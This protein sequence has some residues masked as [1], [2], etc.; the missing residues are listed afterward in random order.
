MKIHRDQTW[1]RR[2]LSLLWDSD[3]LARIVAPGDVVSLRQ[4]CAIA[5]RWPAELPGADGDAL[6][7]AGLEG[8]LDT[9]APD[10]AQTWLEHD[11]KQLILDFQ[12]EYEGSAA[13]IFWLPAGRRRL[14]M[15]RA[16]EAYSW[17]HS[18]AKKPHLPLGRYLWAGAESDVARILVSDEANPDPDGPAY[19]GLYHPRIS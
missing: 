17:Q 6:I 16:T 15:S 12:N 5:R 7:V 1:T 2:G 9:L 11:L 3:A 18:P 8:L 13:L 4:L 14:T 19:I 10:D